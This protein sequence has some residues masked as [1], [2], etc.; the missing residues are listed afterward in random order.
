VERRVNQP[1]S[2]RETVHGFEDADKIAPL[3]RQ[4]LIEC[5]DACFPAVGQD[6]FLD[7]TLAF[8]APLR[9]LEVGE[10]HVF[11]TAQADALYAELNGLA[12]ILRGV[13]VRT[14]TQPARLI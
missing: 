9:L 12:R 4:Q 11:R 7:G 14:D 13:H 3:K 5:L 2:D 1:D 8:M 6:H 10:E